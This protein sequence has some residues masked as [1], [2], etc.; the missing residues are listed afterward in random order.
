MSVKINTKNIVDENERYIEIYK[1]TNIIT[2]KLY[3]GQTVS[4]VLNHGKYRK[5]GCVKRLN[6]HISEAIKRINVIF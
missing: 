4:H 1:I 2:K 3:I 6:S 5:F